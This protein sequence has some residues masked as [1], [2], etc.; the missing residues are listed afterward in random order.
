MKIKIIDKNT[1]YMINLEPVTQLCGISFEKKHFIIKSL[2]KY[3]SSSKYEQYENNMFENIRING[4]KTGRKYFSVLHISSREQLI[5]A[6]NISKS[7]M[8]AQYLS[9]IYTKFSC[10]NII[11]Q[12]RE[13]LDKLY[14]EIN[15]EIQNK[16]GCIEIGHDTKNILEIIQSSN[17][18]G[19]NGNTLE[20]L[21]NMELLLVYINLLKEIQK[22]SPY[23]TLI[24]IENIDHLINYT[25]YQQI[26]K[27][28]GKFSN[29]F[30]VWFIVST[31]T[32]GYAILDNNLIEGINI[33]NDYIFSFPDIEHTISF[34]KKRYPIETTLNETD[35]YENILPIIQNIGR[36]NYKYHMRGNV[37]LKL[38][39]NSIGIPVLFENLIG[40]IEKAFLL[41]KTVV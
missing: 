13:N 20:S 33:I 25:D 1:E 21:S 28:M 36:E 9:C 35:I 15:E 5:Q 12:I 38:F 30:D 8:A 16:I 41:D 34:I 10:Q 26:I 29:S 24:I 37:L 39:Q 22:K 18:F 27:I 4:E 11:E 14:L 31:S 40:S 7:S 3:F 6:L 19:I 23:K 2:C 17:I 32:E